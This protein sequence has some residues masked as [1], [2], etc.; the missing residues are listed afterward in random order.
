[1]TTEDAQPPD[2]PRIPQVGETAPDFELPNC[3]GE[4]RHLE[5]LVAERPLI[6]LFYRGYW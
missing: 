4:T 5:T 1:M 3:A 2:R 6:L